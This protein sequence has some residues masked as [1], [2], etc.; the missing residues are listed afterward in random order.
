MKVKEY[1]E[2][3]KSSLEANLAFTIMDYC[4]SARQNKN[5]SL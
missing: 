2:G 3:L 1:Q 4:I 5:K